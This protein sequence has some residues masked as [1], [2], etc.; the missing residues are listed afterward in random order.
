MVFSPHYFFLSGYFRHAAIF[1]SL[2]TLPLSSYFYTI[3]SSLMF[4][5]YAADDAFSSCRH[6]HFL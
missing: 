4:I 3:F 2:M 5:I 6:Y 1:F